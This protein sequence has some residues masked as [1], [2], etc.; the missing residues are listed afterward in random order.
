MLP[1]GLTLSTAGV[2]SGTPTAPGTYFINL[3]ATDANNVSSFF[4]QSIVI[5]NA[6]LS[7]VSNQVADATVGVQYSAS[8]AG[9]GGTAP[10]SFALASG[11]LPAGLTLSPN[12][13]LTGMATTAGSYP[14]T[15]K[16]TDATGA[17]ATSAVTITVKAANPISIASALPSATPGSAYSYTLVASGGLAPYVFTLD[18]GSTLPTGFSLSTAGVLS[19]TP[20]AAGVNTFTVNVKDANGRTGTQTLTLTTSGGALTIPNASL[21]NGTVG[22]AYNLTLSPAGGTSPYTLSVVGGTLP[23]GVT[24]TPTG[25][26]SGTPTAAGTYPIVLRLTDATGAQVQQSYSIV[27]AA[28]GAAGITF[29]TTTLPAATSGQSYTATLQA[30]GGIAPYTYAVTTGTLPAGLTLASNGTISGMTTGAA[31]QF[32]LTI[33]ATD[34]NGATATTS[35]TL[36][37]N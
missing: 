7:L 3:K 16:I 25:V 28:S 8:F 33:R 26:F 9:T 2:L 20:T 36:T 35:L 15:L 12:G 21:A 24:M 6:G 34:A 32:P 22:T 31:G 23:P 4:S 18:A 19:G 27:V 37:T 1:P 17:T 14:V 5:G 10:Y 13:S 11:T 30:T 29:T